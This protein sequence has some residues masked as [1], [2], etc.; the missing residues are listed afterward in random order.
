MS[1]IKELLKDYD[2]KHVDVFIAYIQQL[3]A[4]EKD[5]KL[6]AWWAPKI[7][8]QQFADVFKKV[9][10]TGMFI[11]GE[12]ITLNYR[13][14]LIVT[15]DYHA[16]INKVILTYP[17]TIFDFQMVHEGDK[18]T[19][20]KKSG[21]V[22]YSHDILDPFNTKKK[23]IGGYGVIKNRKGEFIEF[24]TLEDIE[25]MKNTSLMKG[26][27][28]AWFDRMVLK[29]IIKR[30]C[31]VHF[32]DIVKEIDIIDNESSDLNRTGLNEEIQKEIDAAK[33]EK[34]LGVI[35]NKHVSTIEDVEAFIN[36]LTKRKEEINNG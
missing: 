15:Y 33:D 23:I 18:F 29:S 35:Y 4:E 2:Q 12:S 7:K 3:K 14:K 10:A 28:N 16:Y 25:K 26:I 5:G 1:G 30:I 20:S 9:A 24:L 32:K 19:F 8:D 22:L 11:D 21:K 36:V 6:I 27:W 34:E 13:K 31:N 17:E